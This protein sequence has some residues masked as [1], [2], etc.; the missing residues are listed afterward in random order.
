[1]SQIFWQGVLHSLQEQNV[2]GMN[3]NYQ[4]ALITIQPFKVLET[5]HYQ[6]FID[7]V[8]NHKWTFDSKLNPIVE[9]V[10][11]Q[12]KTDLLLERGYYRSMFPDA[13][14]IVNQYRSLENLKFLSLEL[15]DG[16]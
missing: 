13:Q 8:V 5:T 15:S 16:C 7:N 6:V 9:D 10:W 14:L 2:I 4:G 3:F 12:K 11:H 1:M